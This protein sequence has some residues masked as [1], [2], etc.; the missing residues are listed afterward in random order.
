MTDRSGHYAPQASLN[1][2]ALNELRR[3]GL[4]TDGMK[5]YDFNGDE[6]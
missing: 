4:N 5:Q 2:Q 3:Q 1:D 6:R